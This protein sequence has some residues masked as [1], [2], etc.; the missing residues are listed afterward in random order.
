MFGLQ[1]LQINPKKVLSK[2]KEF[3]DFCL[4]REQLSPEEFKSLN[5]ELSMGA[6]FHI[7]KR[8]FIKECDG[9]HLLWTGLDDRE[10]DL[11]PVHKMDVMHDC[12]GFHRSST[13]S[14]GNNLVKNNE[15]M[16]IP[17]LKKQVSIVRLNDGSVG[18]G[19]N[20][21]LALRNA[22]LKMHLSKA[23]RLS[24]PPDAWKEH[25]GNA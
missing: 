18:I 2:L 23:F 11:G 19:P 7:G 13:M 24:S 5:I 17:Q 3:E 15:V 8:R 25:Y 16:E 20:Y 4:G 9:K 1:S 6:V 21:K 12:P 14:L 22:S 10:Y